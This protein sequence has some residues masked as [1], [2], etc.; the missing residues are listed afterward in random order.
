MGLTRMSH[1]DEM[2]S[3]VDKSSEDIDKAIAA[4]EACDLPAETRSFAISCI[5]LAVWLPRAFAEHKITLSNL[6]KLIFGAGRNKNKP[7]HDV[8]N[9]ESESKDDAKNNTDTQD[10]PSV[11]EAAND[12][13]AQPIDK[14]SAP[15]HGRIPHT[16]YE[17]VTEHHLSID[18]LNAGDLCPLICGG[19]RYQTPRRSGKCGY[20]CISSSRKN[21]CKQRAYP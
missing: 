10:D 9:R 2:P 7:K 21:C 13:T 11:S 20:P 3:V 8:D 5:R 4:I 14:T 12:E 1:A 18:G 19:K 15:G 17:N 16:T 6:R